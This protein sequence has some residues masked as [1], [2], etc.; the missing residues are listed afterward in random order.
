MRIGIDNNGQ[1]NLYQQGRKHTPIVLNTLEMEEEHSSCLAFL[2]S[3]E[4]FNCNVHNCLVDSG[5]IANIMPLSIAKKINAQ[6]S[7]TSVQII[8]LDRTPI[9]AIGELQDVII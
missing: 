8:E 4:I 2:L 5:M 7:K 3:F 6:W 9:L 1:R